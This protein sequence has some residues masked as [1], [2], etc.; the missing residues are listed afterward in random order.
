M[1]SVQ[2]TVPKTVVIIDEEYKVVTTV[3]PDGSSLT[4]TPNYDEENFGRAQSLGYYVADH[5]RPISK[6]ECLEQLR[7]AVWQMTKDHDR[8][9][10]LLAEAEGKPYSLALWHTANPEARCGSLTRKAMDR[11]ERIVLLVQRLL[12]QGLPDG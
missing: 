3:L 9:H 10:V 4:G 8:V 5:S 1:A 12:N 7:A 2:R 6:E 11:E